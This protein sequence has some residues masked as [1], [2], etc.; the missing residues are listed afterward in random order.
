MPDQAGIQIEPERLKFR[1][2]ILANPN[3]F[4]HLEESLLK[5]VKK[6]VSN[7]DY[8][9]LTCVGY[10]PNKH[11]LEATIAIKR[12]S[13]YGGDLC[14]KGTHEYV[15]FFLDYGSGW[16]DA[17]LA[18][19]HVHDIP[20]SDDCAKQATKPLTYVASLKLSPKLVRCCN[21]PVLPKVRAILSWNLVPPAGSAHAGWLPP[22]GGRLECHVQVK[23]HPWNILCI[24]EEIGAGLNQK[25]KMPPLFEPVQ[26]EPIPL[27]DP[28][29]LK[30]NEL[31]KMYSGEEVK[32]LGAVESHRFGTLEL[33]DVLG[34]GEFT[35]ELLA[36]KAQIWKAAGLDLSATLGELQKTNGN[37]SYEQLQCLGLE[38]TLPERLV[39]T[40]RI[41]RPYGYSGN[42]CQAGSKEYVAF[43]ADWDNTC[44]WSYVGTVAVDVHDIASI[45][46]EGLCYSAILPVDLSYH[47]R[48]CSEPK[49]ARLRAV[50]S[51]AVPPSKT[52]PDELNYWGNRL[53]AHVQI[54][55]GE[56]VGEPKAAIWVLGG[57]P[58]SMIDPGDGMTTSSAVYADTSLP[59]DGLGRPCPFGGR[60]NVKGP[61]FPGYQYRIQVKRVADPPA[62]W[63]PLMTPMVFERTDTTTYTKFPDT[64]DGYFNYVPF[65]QNVNSLLGLWDTGGDDLWEVKLD[66]KTIAGDVI[67]FIQLDNTPPTVD[68]HID[69]MGDCK[70]FTVDTSI[71]GTFVARDTHFGS[72]SLSTLPNNPPITP[73]NNPTTSTPSSSETSLPPGDAWSLDTKSPQLMKPCGYVVLL[74][75]TDRSIL[76]GASQGNYSRTSVGFCLRAQANIP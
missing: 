40:F 29:P 57:I 72:F 39:A 30:L 50:L 75:A 1:E 48:Q 60:V 13:G 7:T 54:N 44:K 45:P 26:N 53:D 8:E 73:A 42:L 19:A 64:P 25:L 36:S 59:P 68:I 21:H 62:A 4:G 69:G 71:T 70:D 27:P 66:I 22:W 37:T 14:H 12:P 17:G 3:Y 11:M 32:K 28:P 74:E 65:D 61:T 47:R 41:K 63:A 31:A 46:K 16:V 15:R 20:N 34:H 52:N 56:V 24:L 51:W 6:M 76:N 18:G 38:N 43:W 2:Y 9:Q 33:N 49:I 23:P 67:H 35:D 10:H 55:P 5:P 58:L